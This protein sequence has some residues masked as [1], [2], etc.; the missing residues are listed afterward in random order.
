MTYSIQIPLQATIEIEVGC[1]QVMSYSEI[2]S[3][4]TEVDLKE[5]A[6][7]IPSEEINKSF[8]RSVAQ[9]SLKVQAA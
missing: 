4:I 2:V 3:K 6:L 8:I 1:G 9:N 7:Q 5:A